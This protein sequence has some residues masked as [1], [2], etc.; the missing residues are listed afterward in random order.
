[1][2]CYCV[3][4]LE[5]LG[6]IL[7]GSSL[8]LVDVDRGTVSLFADGAGLLSRHR[9]RLCRGERTTHRR[10]LETRFLLAF[11]EQGVPEFQVI[12]TIHHELPARSKP[13]TGLGQLPPAE[14]VSPARLAMET[15]LPAAS[16]PDRTEPK[17]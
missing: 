1:M 7:A 16:R 8:L 13:A 6:S 17:R 14:P 3:I 5:P 12:R 15:S 10:G 9:L 11:G 4:A 2:N